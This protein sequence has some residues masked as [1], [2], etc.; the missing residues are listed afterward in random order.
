[1]PFKT[2]L[3]SGSLS[4]DE[5]TVSNAELLAKDCAREFRDA[6]WLRVAQELRDGRR[7]LDG[8]IF[9]VPDQSQQTRQEKYIK[10]V[11]AQIPTLPEGGIALLAAM[12]SETFYLPR[13]L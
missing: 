9:S 4:S 6:D 5:K 7:K 11:L 13:E 10:A 3:F 12:L 8:L 1:M 2:E